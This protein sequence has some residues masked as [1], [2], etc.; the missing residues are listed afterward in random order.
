MRFVTIMVFLLAIICSSAFCLAQAI[1]EDIDTT[2][3]Q[4]IDQE[5]KNTRK[6]FSDEMTRQ[7]QEYFKSIDDR[8][9]YYEKTATDLLKSAVYKLGMLWAGIVIF[10]VGITQMLR[11]R[12]E[13]NKSEK[14]LKT[15]RQE[16]ANAVYAASAATKVP[17]ATSP[18]NIIAETQQ[19]QYV[20]NKDFNVSGDRLTPMPA[21]KSWGERRRDK[22][23]K[24]EML[25]I[26]KERQRLLQREFKLTA[27]IPS[28]PQQ[29]YPSQPPQPPPQQAAATGNADVSQKKSTDIIYDF[30]V[31]Y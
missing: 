13:R 28:P 18:P 26:E 24:K 5:H 10:V 29:L 1:P 6:F 8:A 7:R 23:M 4:K 12:L 17:H 30:E 27:K 16:I 3:L 14:M 19:Q 2:T 21:K 31:M 11:L 25:W 9:I 22:K 20:Q 15:I